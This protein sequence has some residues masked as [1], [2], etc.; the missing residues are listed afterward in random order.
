MRLPLDALRC[1]AQ[2][3][4]S[5]GFLST[6]APLSTLGQ[7]D[8]GQDPLAGAAGA[9]RVAAAPGARAAGSPLER[10]D[11]AHA[12]T[13]HSGL[14]RKERGE[15]IKLERKGGLSSSVM[16]TD[17]GSSSAKFDHFLHHFNAVGAQVA[18]A[19]ELVHAPHES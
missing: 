5:S 15:L 9:P 10:A 14:S 12:P 2:D 1:R 7:A 8:A 13:D 3:L 19:H 16:I 17:D 4:E 11:S 6:Q 18:H